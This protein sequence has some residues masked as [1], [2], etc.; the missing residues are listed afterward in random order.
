MVCF[1]VKKERER[2]SAVVA[3]GGTVRHLLLAA[4]R[5]AVASLLR[6]VKGGRPPLPAQRPATDTAASPCPAASPQPQEF[7]DAVR[8][9]RLAALFA[10]LERAAP[11]Q[12]PYLLVCGLDR[13]MRAQDNK[14]YR[15]DMRAGRAVSGRSGRL[16]AG[17]GRLAQPAAAC[18]LLPAACCAWHARPCR[19]F[20]QP[21]QPTWPT[22]ASLPA[23][24][25]LH[26]ALGAVAA[27][28]DRGVSGGADGGV[29]LPGLPGRGGRGA[30][31]AG[32]HAPVAAGAAWLDTCKHAR[33]QRTGLPP[34]Q[35]QPTAPV[36][37]ALLR[38]LPAALPYPAPQAA[39]HVRLVTAAI[40]SAPFQD[41]E[42]TIFL[43]A[44]DKNDSQVG[45]LAGCCLLPAA[46]G[47]GGRA[48]G[49]S[50]VGPAFTQ[51]GPAVQLCKVERVLGAR[52]WGEH[53]QVMGRFG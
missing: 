1:Q 46:A 2:G 51:A 8:A 31:G 15:A 11:G 17:R 40:A 20:L 49:A 38:C 47:G 34:P 26:T 6:A 4:A 32:L 36:C 50:R 18:C 53:V 33:Q 35:Q 44:H 12:R 23:C 43:R 7:I 45:L 14:E 21:S 48:C 5:R 39:E 41:S 52:G 24:L 19:S 30:G 9:D 22:P 29:P 16:L 42:A 3:G 25:P 13:H 10:L 28:P 27:A 37:A